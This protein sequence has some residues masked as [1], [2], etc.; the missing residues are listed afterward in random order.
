MLPDLKL[1]LKSIVMKKVWYWH[2]KAH[3]DQLNE[4]ESPEI[5]YGELIYDKGANG[6]RTVSL[7]NGG[8]KTGQ[9]HA[10]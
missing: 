10:K 6:E 3:I 7:I 9:P 5:I 8:G 2:K 1:Y 4:I